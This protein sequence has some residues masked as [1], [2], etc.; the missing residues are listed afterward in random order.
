MVNPPVAAVILAAGM[1]TRMGQLKQLLE[2]NNRH[3]L[4][5]ALAKLESFPFQ[6][7]YIVVGYEREKIKTAISTKLTDSRVV[8]IYNRQYREGQ[9]TSLKKGLEA[10][11]HGGSEGV[12]IF[13]SDQ[14]FV[15]K[16]SAWKVWSRGVSRL[17]VEEAPFA[18]RPFYQGNLG[19][20]VFM[21]NV[22]SFEFPLNIGDGGGKSVLIRLPGGVEKI[23]VNDPFI[24]FDIDTLEDYELAKKIA[25]EECLEG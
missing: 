21:G 18:V 17:E 4:E 5:I 20:P 7:I 1:G 14:P 10:A 24:C 12:M 23:P 2:L 16:T 25:V 13:L 6:N 11:C 15:G 8:W 22:N 19:H 9:G 3:L